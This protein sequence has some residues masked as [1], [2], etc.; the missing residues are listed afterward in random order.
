ML[1]RLKVYWKLLGR[2][3]YEILDGWWVTLAAAPA[4]RPGRVFSRTC[5]FE[6]VSLRTR[7]RARIVA[8]QDGHATSSTPCRSP[9]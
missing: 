3:L 9:Q 2:H 6:R 5:L 4:L 8:E 1:V 7:D